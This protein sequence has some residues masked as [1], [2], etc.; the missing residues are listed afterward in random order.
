MVIII[1]G[2]LCSGKTERN[3]MQKLDWQWPCSAT[4][5][6]YYCL[7]SLVILLQ[8]F[9]FSNQLLP[10]LWKKKPTLLEKGRTKGGLGEAEKDNIWSRII[11]NSWIL[12]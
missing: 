3:Q 4:I 1:K 12:V 8:M 6:R 5:A 9:S 2:Q 10:L 11:F 7:D